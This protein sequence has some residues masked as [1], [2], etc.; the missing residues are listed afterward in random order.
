MLWIRADNIYDFRH[1]YSYSGQIRI[2]G[3]SLFLPQGSGKYIKGW[4]DNQF[5]YLYVS[6]GL[7]TS[8]LQC[9]NRY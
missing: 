4:F 2:L 5:P 1:S 3:K 6:K 8:I 9:K 7:G